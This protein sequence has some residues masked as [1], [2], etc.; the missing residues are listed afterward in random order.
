MFAEQEDILDKFSRQDN[1]KW[2]TLSRQNL[3]SFV[4]NYCHKIQLDLP[5]ATPCVTT[6]QK[7][8]D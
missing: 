2:T 5:M 7:N 4:K 3:D 8:K 6:I 1:L